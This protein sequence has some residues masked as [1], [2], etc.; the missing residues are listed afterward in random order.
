MAL[1]TRKLYVGGL[2]PSAQQEELQEHFSRYGE[3]L[4]VRVVRDW[5]TGQCRGFAFVEFADD[6]GPRAA[7]QEKEKD[8][9]VF[10]DRTVDVKRARTRPMRYQNEQSFYQYALNQ[11]PIQSPIQSPVHNQ[12]YTQSSSNNSYAG[13]GHRTC[14]PNKVFVGGLRGNVTKEHLQ[15]YFEKF[16]RITDV[17]VIR[18]GASQRSRGF[19]F[20]TF[21]SEEA[22]VNVLESKFH[23]LNGTKVETKRAIPKGHSYY[24]D[25]LQYNPMI[26]N[27][28]NPPIGFA[29]AYPPHMQ[30]IVNNH[31]VMPMPQYMC[32][33]EYVYMMNGGVPL[34]RQGS[35][36]TG[37]G[38]QIGYGYDHVNTNRF[39]AQLGEAKS[40][41]KLIE[42][43]TEQQVDLPATRQETLG[44]DDQATVTTL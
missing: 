27:G 17:V 9:H 2:P 25:R 24:Q 28:N 8:N 3:V 21:D 5:E 35:L 4:R 22:M 1:E 29:G 12:W 44:M 36:N 13:N 6:E 15:S 34:T 16:G 40:D 18:E 7:L 20:I 33:P 43:I 31:Y 23:D 37:Y 11:S 30:H 14:D 39:G 42:D 38:T 41:N 32:L 10:G 26:W 19:G